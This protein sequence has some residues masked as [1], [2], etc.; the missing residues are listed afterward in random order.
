MVLRELG[1]REGEHFHLEGP[2]RE[3]GREIVRQQKGVRPGDIDVVLLGCVQTVDGLLEALAHLHLVDYNHI[4]AAL[5]EMLLDVVVQRAVL[6]KR[7][8]FE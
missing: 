4:I 5:D 7:F 1:E 3:Q 8:E 6:H 2:A